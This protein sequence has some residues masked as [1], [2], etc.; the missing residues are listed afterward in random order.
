MG[1]GGG[2]RGI[3]QKKGTEKRLRGVRL[4]LYDRK[5][6]TGRGGGGSAKVSPGNKS[7]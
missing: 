1:T 6:K 2:N 5:K 7:T 4:D 3:K